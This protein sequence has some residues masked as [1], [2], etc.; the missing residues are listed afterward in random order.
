MNFKKFKYGVTIWIDMPNGKSWQQFDRICTWCE[1]EIGPNKKKWE[2]DTE[3]WTYNGL[4][5][6]TFYFTSQANRVKF[7]AMWYKEIWQHNQR[8]HYFDYNRRVKWCEAQFGRMS[9]S[10]HGRDARWNTY[11]KLKKKQ[12]QDDNW[13]SFR[14]TKSEDYTLYMM[15]WGYD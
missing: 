4:Q 6:F 13:V 5:N 9:R 2:W 7:D 1:D 11:P 8:I 14:F 15:T 12:L 10:I 3:T